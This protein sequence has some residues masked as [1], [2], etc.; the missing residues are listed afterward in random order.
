MNIGV[1]SII[2]GYR[3]LFSDFCDTEVMYELFTD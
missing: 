2:A 1:K 3:H